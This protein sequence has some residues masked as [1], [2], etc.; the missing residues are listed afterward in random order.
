MAFLKSNPLLS[1]FLDDPESRPSKKK[2]RDYFKTVWEINDVNLQLNLI[3]EGTGI[4]FLSQSYFQRIERPKDFIVLKNAP[5]SNI[6]K[7]YGIFY[8]DQ[9]DQNESSSSIIKAI[10]KAMKLT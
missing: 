8:L 9:Y 10:T 6:Q 5:F 3:R 1:S 2:I 4:T 7:Q